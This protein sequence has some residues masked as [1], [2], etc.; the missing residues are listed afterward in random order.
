[1]SSARTAPRLTPRE[2]V[3]LAVSI[4]AWTS[5]VVWL[6]KDTSWDFRNY[7]WYIPY[8]FLN[9]R[10]GIDI[11]VAHQG[12]YYNPLSDVPFY[13]LAVHTTSWFAI[14]VLGLF[15]A[16]NIVPLYVLARNTLRM[17]Q[18]ELA[19]A[20]LAFFGMTGGLTLCLYG[21][22]YYDNVMSLF[23]LT[24]LAILV[25]KRET[26]A[27]GSPKNTFL[28]CALAGFLV[29]GTAGLK[30]PE[31]PFAVG[32]AAALLA[33]GGSR[34]HLFTRLAAGG[35][36]G[37]AGF[38]LF[39]GY[40]MWR[41]DVL[42]G[43]PLFPYFNDVFHSPLALSSPYRD[44]RF[45]PTSTWIA[46]AFPILFSIDWRIADDLPFLDIRVGL[47]YIVAIIALAVWLVGR[48]SKDPLVVP[49]AARVII[50]FAAV[51]Y[52][53]WLKVFAIYRYIVLLEMLAPLII[54]IGVGLLMA[55]GIGKP[56]RA[57]QAAAEKLALGDVNVNIELDSKDE[58]GA[59]A[60][61]FRAMAVVFLLIRPF[62]L[63]AFFIP[64][65]SM[66]PTLLEN[67]RILVNKFIYF[68]REPQRGDI[69]VFVSPPNADHEQKDFIKRVVAGPGD[70]IF[71][72]DDHLY[73]NGQ[74]LIDL[75]PRAV[76]VQLGQHHLGPIQVAGR[77]VHHVGLPYHF[78]TNG[79]VKGDVVPG[80][81]DGL[82]EVGEVLLQ[83]DVHDPQGHVRLQ[84]PGGMLHQVDAVD[85]HAARRNHEGL[86]ADEDLQAVGHARGVAHHQAHGE[87]A[88]LPGFEAA[89]LGVDE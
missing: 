73:R 62:V 77:T 36:G 6:G 87:Q 42:T 46:V 76:V 14:A 47:A 25:A 57:M 67:D 2:I 60:Q 45:L 75:G 18:R 27:Q 33:V 8:A 30:L 40:W 86:V 79:L 53:F 72:A 68:F 71:V 41:M 28:W 4:L 83:E 61:S 35:L 38:L 32:F 65:G 39:A 26:L 63:Q 23:I 12:S 89:G 7:H 31:M 58:L 24:S 66:R 22:H 70:R 48:R 80:Q 56:L 3:F 34:K 74:P 54:A 37:L 11:A 17:E 59:L 88:V 50:V 69:V 44:M 20:A 43:N 1:M 84:G 9:D 51:S 10:M 55:R 16:A 15:Q 5:Y 82:A 29:G 49:E 78:G 85:L 52:F 21:T 64:S 19:S 81:G 13:W